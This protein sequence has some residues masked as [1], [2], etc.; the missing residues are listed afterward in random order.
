[1]TLRNDFH[2]TAVPVRPRHGA[3]SALTMRRVHRVLCGMIDCRCGGVRGPQYDETGARV[4][5]EPA[6]ASGR[7]FVLLAD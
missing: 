7:V 1:M 2:Q 4:V 5:L 3:L 6:D